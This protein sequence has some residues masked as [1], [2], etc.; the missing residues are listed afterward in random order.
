MKDYFFQAVN[1]R[2]EIAA[3]NCALKTLV[4]AIEGDNKILKDVAIKLARE[5]IVTN[6]GLLSTDIND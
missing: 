3:S 6:S 5:Q 1:A 4:E 2:G